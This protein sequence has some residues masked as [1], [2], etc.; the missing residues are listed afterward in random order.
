MSDVA[1]RVGVSQ[2]LVSL[3]FRNQPGASAETRRRVFRA[4]EELGYRPD[5]AAQLLRR[6]RS[7]QL[8][9][10]FTMRHPYDVGIV[11]A[12]YPAAQKHGYTLVLNAMIATRGERQSMEELLG[13]RSEAV[14]TIGATSS[15]EHLTT[16]VGRAPIVEINPRTR[17]A[18]VDVVRTAE[19]KGIR[20]AVDHLVTLGHRAIAHIDGGAMPSADQRRRGYRAAMRRHGLA[21]HIRVLP[22][23]YTEESG[24]R[25]ARDLLA[26]PELPTAVIAGNDRC[27]HGLLG[28]LL[29]AGVRVPEDVSI[30]GYDD[31]QLARLSFIDL[32]SVR[33]EAAEAAELAVRAAAERL[34]EG[35]TADR[36][37]VLDPTLVVRGSTGPPRTGSTLDG[38][39][40]R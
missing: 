37:I 15:W 27:A 5:T 21:D 32:T 14:I 7:R 9:V 31:S 16:G 20:Q 19:T 1:A 4:A 30:V 10:L 13:L 23:D 28:T 11:E 17:A 36:D 26:R 12:L 6:T 2:A 40:L 39:H 3:V 35:R 25:A 33:Q 38:D 24:A 34:D 18:G 8:G 29:R 22:G